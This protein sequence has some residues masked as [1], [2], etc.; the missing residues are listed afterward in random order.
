MGLVYVEVF[1]VQQ[2]FQRVIVL[3]MCLAEVQNNNTKRLIFDY[4]DARLPRVE[5]IMGLLKLTP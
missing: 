2:V 5:M 1:G 4:L 3:A